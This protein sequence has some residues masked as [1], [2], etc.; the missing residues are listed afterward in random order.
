MAEVPSW[1]KTTPAYPVFWIK[2][3]V[4][5]NSFSHPCRHTPRPLRLLPA[6]AQT[7]WLY[8][9]LAIFFPLLPSYSLADSSKELKH[10]LIKNHC[11]W[12]SFPC[13]LPGFPAGSQHL[14]ILIKPQRE[15]GRGGEE[16]TVS[17]VLASRTDDAPAEK[18][19]CTKYTHAR[20]H[21]ERKRE[22]FDLVEMKR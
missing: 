19:T 9:L 4:E 15:K 13:I 7:V 20:T 18:Q 3:Q 12:L 10:S 17:P 5:H 21:R 11:W 22:S 1:E 16:R 8:L 14:E 2:Q 6:S